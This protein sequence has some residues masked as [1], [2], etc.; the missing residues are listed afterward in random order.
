MFV[1]CVSW[2][3]MDLKWTE[4]SLRSSVVLK[5]ILSI[6]VIIPAKLSSKCTL[7]ILWTLNKKSIAWMAVTSRDSWNEDMSTQFL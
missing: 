4:G 1:H 2:L 7:K 5:I 6:N 3:K